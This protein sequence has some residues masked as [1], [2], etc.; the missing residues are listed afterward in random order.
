[1]QLADTAS[2]LKSI[3]KPSTWFPIEEPV[4]KGLAGWLAGWLALCLFFSFFS[5]FFFIFSI[6]ANLEKFDVN[7]SF[8]LTTE[9]DHLLVPIKPSTYNVS[10]K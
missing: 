4:Q 5:H 9:F 7:I 10:E 1:M 2:L 8:L 6:S 3:G